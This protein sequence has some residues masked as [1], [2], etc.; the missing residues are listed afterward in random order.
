MSLNKFR[1]VVIDPPWLERGGGK[2]KRGADKHY[3]LLT[4]PDIIRVI[5]QCPHWN[6]I[7]DNAHLYLWSTN[8]FLPQ[9]IKVIEALGFRYLTNICW[10]KDRIGL[11]QY[12]RGKHELCLFGVRGRG[13]PVRTDDRSI[14]SIITAK[15][16]IHSKKPDVFYKTV[17]KRSHGPYLDMFARQRR[18][19]WTVW[20]NHIKNIKV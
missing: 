13:V 20:G 16:T 12:F 7:D 10:V 15:K 9:G 14:P 5:H 3:N 18:S 6:S 17:E 19:N 4:V 2:I 8:S 11:G 1:T